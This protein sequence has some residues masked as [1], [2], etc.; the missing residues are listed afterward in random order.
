M[1]PGNLVA[2]EGKIG[3]LE[4]GY[5][6]DIIGL[7]ENPLDNIRALENVVFV[8]KGGDVIKNIP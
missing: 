1:H 7:D 8:M 4:N 3:V 2:G 6:A 5:F